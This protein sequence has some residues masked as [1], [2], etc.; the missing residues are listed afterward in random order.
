[1]GIGSSHCIVFLSCGFVGAERAATI[2]P[3]FAPLCRIARRFQNRMAGNTV[4]FAAACYIHAID[5]ENGMPGN[6]NILFLIIGAL[7]VGVGV[8]GYNLYQ[9][10]KEPEGLQINVGPNGLKIQNK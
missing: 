10:K 2:K 8:L 1:L 4:P 9:T 5:G 7:I 6:R 3:Y